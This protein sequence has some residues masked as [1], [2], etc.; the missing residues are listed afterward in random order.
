MLLK[1]A[2]GPECKDCG[3]QDVEIIRDAKP[4]ERV[5]FKSGLARCK[6]CGAK[7]TFREQTKGRDEYL[8]D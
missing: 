8:S 6:H 1:K 2:D 4:G 5:W 7:F 3:C